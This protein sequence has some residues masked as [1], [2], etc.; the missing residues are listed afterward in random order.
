MPLI[1][2]RHLSGML[3]GFPVALSL[4]PYYIVVVLPEMLAELSRHMRQ[5]YSST[6]YTLID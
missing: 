3:P 5:L 2:I 4:V 1:A 6:C